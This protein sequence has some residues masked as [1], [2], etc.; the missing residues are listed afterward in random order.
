MVSAE[1]SPGRTVGHVAEIS[2]D[3][4][5]LVETLVYS[6]LRDR[7]EEHAGTQSLGSAVEH[8][9]AVEHVDCQHD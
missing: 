2:L 4:P 7:A 1:T 8:E 5:C 6:E 9:W 3:S